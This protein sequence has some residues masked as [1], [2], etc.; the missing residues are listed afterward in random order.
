MGPLPG[1]VWYFGKEKENCEVLHLV[2]LTS[3]SSIDWRDDD[4]SMAEPELK[5]NLVLKYYTVSKTSK[6]MLASPD[7]NNCRM[8]PLEF[9]KGSDE[10][11]SYVEVNV[12]ALKYWDMLV[13][14]KA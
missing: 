9:K 4:G 1:V 8:S 10:K 3:N 5:Q 14:E 6:V 11:G 7:L 2:N 13:F 12:P